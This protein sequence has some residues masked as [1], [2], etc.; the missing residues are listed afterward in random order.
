[1]FGGIKNEH[2]PLNER[3]V[4][5]THAGAGAWGVMRNVGKMAYPI[6]EPTNE[7]IRFRVSGVGRLDEDL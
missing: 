3:R 7:R 2:H 5:A 6:E 4:D 1:M